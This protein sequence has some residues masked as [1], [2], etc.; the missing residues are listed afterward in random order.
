M[1][2]KGAALIAAVNVMIGVSAFW[3]I[4]HVQR[5]GVFLL[6]RPQAETPLGMEAWILKLLDYGVGIAVG[7]VFIVWLLRTNKRLAQERDD[8]V[9]KLVDTLKDQVRK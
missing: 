5:L 1:F 6:L 9:D 8:A 2:G 4:E 3:T 7:A